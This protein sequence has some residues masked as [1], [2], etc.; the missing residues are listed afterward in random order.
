MASSTEERNIAFKHT[1]DVLHQRTDRQ[2]FEEA[3]GTRHAVVGP[4]VWRNQPYYNDAAGAVSAGL[5][6]LET[7]FVLTLDPFSANTTWFA[8]VNPGVWPYSGPLTDYSTLDS[9]RIQNWISPIVFGPSSSTGYSYTLK[10]GDGTPIPTGSWEFKFV[11]GVL[12]LDE[13]STAAD[14]G[15]VTPLKLTAYRYPGPFGFGTSA[16]SPVVH[17]TPTGTT[18]LLEWADGPIHEVDLES[19]SGNV[20][21]LF[22]GPENGATYRVMITQGSTPRTLVW[23]AGISWSTEGLV[24]PDPSVI[25]DSV[26]VYTLVYDGTEYVGWAST[27]PTL[28]DNVAQA[29]CLSANIVGDA[30]YASGPESGGIYQVQKTDPRNENKMPAI[31]VIV[32]KQSATSCWIQYFGEMKGVYSGLSTNTSLF[33]GTNGRLSSTPPTAL[34]G[35]YALVQAA[36]TAVGPTTI[37]FNPSPSMIKRNG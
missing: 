7:D 21:L 1:L 31:G 18:Q 11:E 10:Q 35:G 19:A 6:I 36:G 33:I 29:T 28:P 5:A 25:N 23:P 20:S 30:V 9:E 24:P 17:H 16:I 37:L 2:W 12:H 15:W 27:I 14:K 3:F 4:E 13:G 22:S 32:S 26:S 8:K 34:P